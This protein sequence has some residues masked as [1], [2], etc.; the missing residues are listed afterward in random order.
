M[1]R[2]TPDSS[3][4]SEVTDMSEKRFYFSTVLEAI[5]KAEKLMQKYQCTGVDAGPTA[6]GR[7][8]L[9]LTGCKENVK[10]DDDHETDTIHH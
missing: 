2:T 4:C 1:I 6:D 7:A 5:S 3:D 8:V 10:E 9:I